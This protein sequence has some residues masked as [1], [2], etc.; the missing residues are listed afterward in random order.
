MPATIAILDP[1]GILRATDTDTNRNLL[2]TG[3]ENLANSDHL[4]ITGNGSATVPLI[5]IAA[6]NTAHSTSVGGKTAALGEGVNLTIT[7]QASNLATK[8]GGAITITPGAGTT[9]GAGGAFTVTGGTA[10]TT[11]AGGA[12]A[13]TGGTGGTTSGAGGNV[14]INAGTVTSG[15]AGIVRLAQNVAVGA[16]AVNQFVQLGATAGLGI[17]FANA[18][19]NSVLTAAQGSLCIVTNGSGVGNRLFINTTGLAV[20]TSVTTAA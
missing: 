2:S 7:A 12:I 11:G 13:I 8:A 1:Q 3:S 6:R 18:T 20:W 16:A 17:Y 4:M 9:T 10:G 5:T 19:P 14:T 15:T